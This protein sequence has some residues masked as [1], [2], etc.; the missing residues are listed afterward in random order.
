MRATNGTTD[1]GART[2]DS[3]TSGWPWFAPPFTYLTSGWLRPF[4]HHLC[5][6]ASD[7]HCGRYPLSFDA[8]A[9]FHLGRHQELSECT[10]DTLA[11]DTGEDDRKDDIA[12]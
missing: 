8:A 1:V 12:E 11:T 5:D 10:Q 9:R 7:S 4:Y 2:T 6:P 3:C